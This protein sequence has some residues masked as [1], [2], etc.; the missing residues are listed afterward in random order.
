MASLLAL[1]LIPAVE[2]SEADVSPSPASWSLNPIDPNY[3]CGATHLGFSAPQNAYVQFAIWNADETAIVRLLLEQMVPA[4]LHEILWDGHDEQGVPVPDGQY[5]YRLVAQVDGS[6]VF[7]SSVVFE[8]NCSVAVE[9]V[10]WG[11]LKSSYWP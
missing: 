7:D 2:A 6:T 5:L 8:V 3:L 9:G 1:V 10:T 11:S 4:G